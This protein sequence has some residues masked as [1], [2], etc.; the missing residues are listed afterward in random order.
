MKKLVIANRGEIARRILRAG[1]ERAYT[2]AVISTAEDSD[3]LV[4]KEA[5][6]VII[7]ASFLNAKE[8]IEKS[9]TWELI[10]YIL[11][12]VFYLKIQNLLNL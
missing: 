6:Y 11:A 9:V 1:Q 4:C 12:M 7:V 3:S 5:D 10:T 2:V 8:I